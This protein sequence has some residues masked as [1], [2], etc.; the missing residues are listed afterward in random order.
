MNILCSEMSVFALMIAGSSFLGEQ[1]SKAARVFLWAYG[2][3]SPAQRVQ[4]RKAVLKIPNFHRK[5][6][7]GVAEQEFS[8]IRFY[9]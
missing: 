9:L 5:N 3:R 6:V 7:K 8:A 2:T 4:A 1:V